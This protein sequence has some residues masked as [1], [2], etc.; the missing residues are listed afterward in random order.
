MKNSACLKYTNTC[1]VNNEDQRDSSDC[2]K[3]C[4]MRCLSMVG[5]LPT[6]DGGQHAHTGSELAV[7]WPESVAK[8]ILDT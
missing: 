4:C 7:N 3:C 1:L 5:V 6:V 8:C 2:L